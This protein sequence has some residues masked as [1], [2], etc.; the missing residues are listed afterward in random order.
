MRNLF[1]SFLVLVLVCTARVT[2]AQAAESDTRRA[3][4]REG[5]AAVQAK[6]WPEAYAIFERLWREAPTYDVA[7]HLGHA[8]YNLGK[9]R[10][11]A[12][13]LA[14]GVAHLPPGEAKEVAEGAKRALAR[15]KEELCTITLIVDRTGAAVRVDGESKGTTPVDFEIFVEPGVHVIDATLTGYQTATERFEAAQGEHRN[16][17]LKLDPLPPG[18]VAAGAGGSTATNPT[19]G[20]DRQGSSTG[21]TVA[22]LTGAGV[23]L[24]AGVTTLVFGIKGSS[25]G[26]RAED[27]R[28][29]ANR[30]GPNACGSPMAA[31]AGLCASIKDAEDDRVAANRGA[32]ISLAVTGVAAVATATMFFVW[33]RKTSERAGAITIAPSASRDAGALFVNGAF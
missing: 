16:V 29:E 18:A 19:T 4:Y 20:E 30:Y 27:A 8:E 12:E 13:H 17:V 33:P 10:E 15:I 9:K 31:P 21:R 24:V 28:A 22:L 7:L 5:Y 25:A 14:F 23:T 26:N 1:L 6:N 2:T 32:N 11:A 3:A